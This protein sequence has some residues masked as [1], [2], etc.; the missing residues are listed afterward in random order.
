MRFLRAF[1]LIELLVVIAIIA[2][3]AAILFPVFAQAKLA[4]KK[5]VSLSNMKQIGLGSTLYFNDFD[6]NAPPLLYMDFGDMSVPSTAG[7][8]YWPVLLLPYTKSD[9][10]FLDPLDTAQGPAAYG[11]RFDSSGPY[12]DLLV[13]AWPSYGFNYFYLNTKINAPNPN[14]WGQNPYYV[15]N[16]LTSISSSAQTILFAEATAKDVYDPGTNTF[17]TTT[18]GYARID[19]PSRWTGTYPDANS[20][21]HLWPRYSPNDTLINIGWVDGH[22]K[23]TQM[24]KLKGTGT[25]PETLDVLWNGTAN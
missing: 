12:Y 13:G 21:G 5:A 7:L 1:T 4:A 15:G 18:V 19:P 20:Q 17:T 23:V 25:T 22:V 11:N 8:Y 9:K 10:I 3:L 16:S 14:G 24:G 6:D 2:I